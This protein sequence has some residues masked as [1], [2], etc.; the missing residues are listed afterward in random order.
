M[1][2]STADAEAKSVM[3]RAYKFRLDP[4][5]EQVK[6]L[7]QAAGA[8]RYTYNMM[9]AYNLE[10]KKNRDEFW[11]AHITED[12]DEQYKKQVES[13]LKALEKAEPAR[14]KPLCQYASFSTQKLTP[15]KHK[16][17]EVSE[18]IAQGVLPNDA[19][20]SE[21][22]PKNPWLHEANQRVLV[23]GL[24]NSAKAWKN[25]WDSQTGRRKGAK[26]NLPRL[27]K[28][29]ISRDSFTVPAPEAM[30]GYGAPYKNDSEQYKRL[31]KKGKDAVIQDYRHVR[32]SYL[33]VLRTFNSTKPLAKAVNT[34]AKIKSYT[35]SRNADRWYVSFLVELSEPIARPATKKQRAAGGVGIDL[36]VKTLVTLSD[37]SNP[38]IANLRPGQRAQRKLKKLQQKFARS[39]KGSNRRARLAAEIARLHHKVALRRK[40]Y[41]DQVTKG[42]VTQYSAVACED[43]NVSGMVHSAKGTVENPGKNVAAKSGLNRSILDASFG[44]FIRQL[45]YKSAW[46][47]SVVLKVDKWFPSSRTCFNCGE[48]KSK[49]PLSERVYD[50]QYCGYSADR[51]LNAARNILEQAYK[52]KEDKQNPQFAPERGE[53]SN[54]RGRGSTCSVESGETSRP[55]DGSAG[56]RR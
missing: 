22:H 15:A 1:V 17:K 16:H 6:A 11:Y 39:Q 42:L 13:Q 14:Y 32:L 31:K 35:V 41:L 51:D 27:K 23:S 8:A 55:A 5:N 56:H 33:G 43:L 53:N 34:G 18:A 4:N 25:F 54:G 48:V 30:G 49:L 24:Q 12:S 36:G 47:G 19:W 45:E 21:E 29:G 7:Y 2:Q 9:T 50:C 3:Y 28:R 10:I 46:Y 37:E 52:E 44:M 20:G 40:G 38:Y 26:V